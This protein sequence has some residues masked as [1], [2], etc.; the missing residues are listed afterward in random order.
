MNR[1][2]ATPGEVITLN[3]ALSTGLLL[4]PLGRIRHPAS[5][6]RMTV[7]EAVDVGFLD[8]DCSVIIDPATRREV[9]LTDAQRCNKTLITYIHICK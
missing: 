1:C 9:T 5:N 3:E 7:E 4:V 8:P 2:R 6:Q